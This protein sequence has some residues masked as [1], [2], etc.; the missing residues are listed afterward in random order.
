MRT[1]A[2]IDDASASMT[3]DP[4]GAPV[5]ARVGPWLGLVALVALYA[6]FQVRAFVPAYNEIDPDG[7]L[8][9]AKRI[10]RFE[11][12]A[13]PD[14]LFL[15]NSHVWVEPAPGRVVPKFAPGYPAVLAVFYRMFGDGGM[16]Y[17]S[18]LMGGLALVGAFVLFRPW[19][20]TALSL[21]AVATLLVNGAFLFY[22][23][24]LLPHATELAFITWGMAFLWRWL[25]QPRIADGVAAGLLLG[26]ACTIRHTAALLVGAVA[27]ALLSSLVGTPAL[28]RERLVPMLTLALAYGIFPLAMLAYNTVVFGGPLVTGYAL[29]DEQVPLSW[30][31]FFD[32]EATQRA[33]AFSWDLLAANVNNLLH[34]MN[35]ELMFMVFPLGL[36]G[37]LFVGPLR[38]RLLRVVWWVPLV[39]VYAAYYFAPP[40]LA[41]YRFLLGVVPVFIGGTYLL[42]D[43]VA[44]NGRARWLL[45]AAVPLAV[46]FPSLGYV[47]RT[48]ANGA[49][50]SVT[51]IALAARHA[52][53][54]L[55]PDAVIFA[56]PPMHQHLGTRA[57]FRVYN[58]PAF[59]SDY[60]REIEDESARMQSARRDRLLRL[61]RATD[62]DLRAVQ[63]EKIRTFVKHGRQV[64]FLVSPAEVDDFQPT[65]I[66]DGYMLKRVDEWDAPGGARWGLYAVI[67]A[68]APGTLTR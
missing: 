14:D 2:R 49:R 25:R 66:P 31:Q 37:M 5:R 7:Y 35:Y 57:G 16:F 12:P 52:G 29:S 6:V 26:Y 60:A 18:P 30:R 54:A 61:Y 42:L 32:P 13:L 1:N 62:A 15:Y 51:T 27:W 43:R 44:L 53:T 23:S 24:Y 38:E 39:V 68:V 64:A 55:R 8:V 21:F 17:V 56:A 4:T 33:P 34:G 50:Q 28:R 22:S 67:P 20:S 58:V 48:L 47:E 59:R 65:V 19:M 3:E 45:M 41:Y 9:L 36:L 11:S 63:R 46:A 10:A 40:N